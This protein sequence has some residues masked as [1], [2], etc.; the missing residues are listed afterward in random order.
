MKNLML[1]FLFF[2]WLLFATPQSWQL[3]SP[4]K[5]ITI[6]LTLDE[7]RLA[8][9]VNFCYRHPKPADICRNS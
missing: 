8:Y 4:D 6:T 5:Q 7:T 1:I 3:H 2:P 9:A